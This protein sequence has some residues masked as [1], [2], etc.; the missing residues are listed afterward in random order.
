MS[1]SLSLL[2]SLSLSVPLLQFFGTYF[3]LLAV[4]LN[5][6]IAVSYLS[7]SKIDSSLIR[8]PGSWSSP[9]I[10]LWAWNY[11]H[12]HCLAHPHRHGFPHQPASFHRYRY[13][14][15][16]LQSPFTAI[17]GLLDLVILLDLHV[18][19]DV[20]WSL[21]DEKWLVRLSGSWK[22]SSFQPGIRCSGS[23]CN[24]G[25]DW[26]GIWEDPRIF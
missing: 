26:L 13:L 24:H 7:I 11:F 15:L 1:L 5:S 14:V 9:L 16:K 6:I 4:G 18:I 20:G 25:T 12:C 8:S 10:G 22:C 3:S 23:G 2:N 19:F 17:I 21:H